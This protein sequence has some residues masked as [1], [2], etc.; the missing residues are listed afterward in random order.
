MLQGGQVQV[1]DI[2]E[3]NNS[4]AVLRYIRKHSLKVQEVRVK[5]LDIYRYGR[6]HLFIWDCGDVTLYQYTRMTTGDLT[7]LRGQ[8]EGG[9]RRFP[10]VPVR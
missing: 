8:L 6:C 3:P 5:E 7:A 2:D 4:E 10:I 9:G 1:F